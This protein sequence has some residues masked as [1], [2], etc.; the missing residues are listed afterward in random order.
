MFYVASPSGTWSFQG[1]R[2]EDRTTVG[3]EITH[4]SYPPPR[5]NA[6]AH[7]D[8]EADEYSLDRSTGTSAQFRVIPN[9]KA[10]VAFLARFAKASADMRSLIG[11]VLWSPLIFSAFDLDE[12]CEDFD[13]KEF[14]KYP[15]EN[16]AWGIAYINPGEQA[17]HTHLGEITLTFAKSG[18]QWQSGIPIQSC[19]I[20]SNRL[21][22]KNTEKNS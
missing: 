2:G 10:L 12:F 8:L 1:L 14:A 16:L 20:S 13:G 15:D 9:S 17:L 3:F 5:Q 18:G 11:G 22:V 19:I 4:A 21:V 6:D 7:W